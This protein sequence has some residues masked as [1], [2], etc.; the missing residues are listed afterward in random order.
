M[1][2]IVPALCVKGPVKVTVPA[3]LSVSLPTE[4]DH[5]IPPTRV[6]EIDPVETLMLWVLVLD[7]EMVTVPSMVA[8]WVPT[9]SV[10][11]TLTL[12]GLTVKLPV[13]PPAVVT[14]KLPPVPTAKVVVVAVALPMVREA[15][16]AAVVMVRLTP[17]LMTASSA[18]V[19]TPALQVAVA[20]FDPAVA[21]VV[22][23]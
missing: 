6:N 12:P 16:T 14:L 15:Q 4:E 19:G 20:Q 23:A 9:F 8:D 21:V 7:E 18:L 2:R 22:T 11:A 1:F 3:P 13:P 5:V 17:E 10:I